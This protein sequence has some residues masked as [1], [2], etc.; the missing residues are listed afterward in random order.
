MGLIYM[1][2]SYPGVENLLEL[3]KEDICSFLMRK[4]WFHHQE[5]YLH[6]I[7]V[8][9]LCAELFNLFG[10][11]GEEQETLLCSVL[12]HDIG[13]IQIDKALLDKHDPITN[14]EWRLLK[15]HCRNGAGILDKEMMGTGFD[16][17]IILYHHENMDGSGYYGLKER[18]LSLGVRIVRVADSYDAMVYP[19]VYSKAKDLPETFEELFLLSGIHYDPNVVEALYQVKKTKRL[20]ALS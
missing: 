10:I 13:K 18:E 1:K 5:T 17:D 14:E 15:N 20:G 6:S 19:R 9:S 8:T 2:K 3:K 16:L 4:L 12:L 11:P 7:R